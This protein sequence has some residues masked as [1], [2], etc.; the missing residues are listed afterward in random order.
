M[1]RFFLR[2]PGFRTVEETIEWAKRNNVTVFVSDPRA[3][4]PDGSIRGT[5]EIQLQSEPTYQQEK[6]QQ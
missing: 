4:S 2:S 3:W 5:G 1:T 6:K